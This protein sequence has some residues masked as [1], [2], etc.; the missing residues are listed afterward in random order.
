[1]QC[2]RS[3]LAAFKEQQQSTTMHETDVRGS[4]PD[5]PTV[6]SAVSLDFMA[7]LVSVE[8]QTDALKQVRSVWVP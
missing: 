2:L 3:E 7:R 8:Q 1:M 5:G 4:A 6:V